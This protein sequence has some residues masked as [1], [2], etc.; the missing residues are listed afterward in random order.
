MIQRSFF[1]NKSEF[2][3]ARIEHGGDQKGRRKVFRP[4][5]RRKPVHVVLKSSH[6]QGTLSLITHKL[7]VASIVEAKANKYGVKIHGMEIMRDHVHLVVS[8]RAKG[9]MQSFLKVSAGLIAKAVTGAR[10]GRAFGKRFWDHLVFTRI[11]TGKRDF[12]RVIRYLWK[13]KIERE[14]GPTLRWLVEDNERL[15]K[16]TRKKIR[17]SASS[18]SR[19]REARLRT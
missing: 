1:K 16:E 3:K 6:A 5:D 4:L 14:E 10:K 12:D 19:D 7:K 8:F 9:P 18:A 15:D 17:R 13:N 2:S 11:I